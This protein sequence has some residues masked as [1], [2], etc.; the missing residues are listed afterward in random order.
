MEVSRALA[1]HMFVLGGVE[2]TLED[3]RARFDSVISSGKALDKFAQC[4]AEQ[5]GDPRVVEDYSQMPAALHLESVVAPRDGYV[6]ALEAET[7]GLAAVTLGA[8]RDRLDSIV[9]PAVGL[10]LEKKIGDQ[11]RAGERCCLIR[12]NDRTRLARAIGMVRSAITV[13]EE[14]AVAPLLVRETIT[15]EA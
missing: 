15:S 4:I 5:G 6:A 13:S 7:L 14:R 2:G 8:G 9:D 3:A 1:S 12:Y 11:I 10:V